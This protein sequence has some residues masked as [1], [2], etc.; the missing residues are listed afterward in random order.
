VAGLLRCS[1]ALR[2]IPLN[3]GPKLSSVFGAPLAHS[4]EQRTFNPLVEGSKPSR[5]TRKGPGA[6][7]LGL[8]QWS[9][10]SGPGRAEPEE[11]ASETVPSPEILGE[12]ARPSW[13]TIYTCSVATNSGSSVAVFGA[14]SAC[15]AVAGVRR[16]SSKTVGS[17]MALPPTRT[18]GSSLFTGST[19]Y[20]SEGL[21]LAISLS[22]IMSSLQRIQR[23]MSCSPAG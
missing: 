13:P 21:W 22:T 9:P 15:C 18:D 1:R 5:C 23:Q 3:T 19:P 16:V 11:L 10:N 7:R 8:F 14:A 20:P 6:N 12:A 2:E 4:V 17:E